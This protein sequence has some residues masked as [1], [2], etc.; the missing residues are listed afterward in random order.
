MRFKVFQI[1][2]AEGK[3]D[4]EHYILASSMTRAV[5]AVYDKYKMTAGLVFPYDVNSL[6]ALQLCELSD[7]KRKFFIKEIQDEAL[8][9]TLE[10]QHRILPVAEYQ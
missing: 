6:D 5:N 4:A 7:G 3:R 1:R 8:I 2:K 9:K 10:T